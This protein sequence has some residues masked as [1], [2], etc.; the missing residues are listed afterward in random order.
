[1]SSLIPP[2]NMKLRS[3]GSPLTIRP[4]VWAL[5]MLSIPSR[6]AVPGAIIS[7]ALISPG[8]GLTSLS[9][10]S[11]VRGATI[12]DSRT[13][14]VALA[15]P[16]LAR[17]GTEHAPGAASVADERDR[18]TSPQAVPGASLGPRE[19]D[20]KSL[21]QGRRRGGLRAAAGGRDRALQTVLGGL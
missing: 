1:M 19:R 4:P 11:P 3:S 7:N 17:G 10:S 13:F 16:S 2:E 5:R 20:R 9:R 12:L 8:S 15:P 21:P 6:S 14:S 18:R